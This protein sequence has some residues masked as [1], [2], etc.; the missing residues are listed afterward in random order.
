MDQATQAFLEKLL[1]DSSFRNWAK[2]NNEND[3]AFWNAWI[4]DNPDKIDVVYNAKDIILGIAFEKTA[5]SEAHVNKELDAVLDKIQKKSH[6]R[7]SKSVV[8]L[9]KAV[10]RVTALAAV[11]LI[12]MVVALNFPR[13][14]KEIVHKTGFGEV[15]NLKLPD[16]TSVVLNGNSEIRYGKEDSRDIT[17][18]GEAYFKVKPQPGTR[19]KFWV[20]TEDLRVEVYGTQF[21]VNTRDRKTD[22]T[23]D[24]GSINLLLKNGVAKKMS[25]GEFISYS[26]VDKVILH[27]GA[28]KTNTYLWRE[29]TYV[30]NNI[31]L[32]EVMKHLGHTY[33]LPAEFMDKTLE[34]KTLTGGIP[35]ENLK[36]CL[37]AIE[38][39]TGTRIV[40]QDN[41]LIIYNDQ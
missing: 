14:S 6:S 10:K 30:F 40:Q 28:E 4:K 7:D 35:N 37:S 25:P 18:K 39:T 17:L 27:E 31:T 32:K 2:N 13:A 15:I 22:V 24:E 41:K 26:N 11:G 21:H 5:V 9:S 8:Q 29:G 20:N 1:S 33:G 3:V 34:G 38:K 12:L 23:L 36:I 19:A 16:G